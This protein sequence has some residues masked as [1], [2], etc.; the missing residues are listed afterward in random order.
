M[1]EQRII[2]TGFDVAPPG[3]IY[4]EHQM[5]A[6]SAMWLS[7][8]AGKEMYYEGDP[9]SNIYIPVFDSFDDNRTAVAVINA[10]INWKTYFTHVLPENI[11]GVHVV[12]VNECAGAYTYEVNGAQVKGLGVGDLHDPKFNDLEQSLSFR[13]ITKVSDGTQLGLDLNQEGCPYSLHIYPSQAFYDDYSTNNPVVVTCSVAITFVFMAA[14]FLLYDRLVERRQRLVM[15]KANQ[16]TALVSSLFPKNV[17]DRLLA[18]TPDRNVNHIKSN[19]FT[20]ASRRV[21]TFLADGSTDKQHDGEQPIADLFPHATVMFADIAGFT[22]WA[23]TRDP[24]Q[25]F[26]LLQ[27]IYREFDAIA[28]K[29]KVFKVET[30]GK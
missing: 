6:I 3:D 15:F 4:A 19:T 29:R 14:M 25:V 24:S 13:D 9:N 20:S 21:K 12:L 30:I 16:S 27:S 8:A 26:I 10:I 23:S 28:V 1:D 11:K 2:L 17:R 7:F 22:A 18:D 5:T